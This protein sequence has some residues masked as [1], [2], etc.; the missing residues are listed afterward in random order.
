MAIT[1]KPLIN[2]FW[3]RGA[4]HE[5]GIP[6]DFSHT[7]P[8]NKTQIFVLSP[9]VA[10]AAEKLVRS[11][12]FKFPDLKDHHMPYEHTA[13]EYEITPEIHAI[14]TASDHL[15]PQQSEIATITNIGAH[16]WESGPSRFICT[17]YWRLA[18]G[19]M[20]HS[21]FSFT[22]GMN[23]LDTHKILLSPKKVMEGA[24]E[25]GV[26]LS[27]AVLAGFQKANVPTDSILERL[28]AGFSGSSDKEA[29]AVLNHVRE[30]ISELPLL[31]FACA[32]L[33]NC[34]TGVEKKHVAERK[35][36]NSAYGARLRKKMSSAAF[37]VVHLSALEKVSDDGTIT[38]NVGM[39]AHYVR[40]HFKQ[41][42][43]GVYWW[44]PFVRGSGEPR[45]RAAYAVKE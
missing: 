39:A 32:M 18:N 26:I 14:R 15:Y 5:H 16:V 8:P 20:Q 22:L 7:A 12:S 45:K 17:P 9:E 1:N 11:E 37:T 25:T 43:S 13:I 31:A 33:I 23:E 3:D 44:S 2:L 41:R 6:V 19:Q 28:S 30:S 35:F 40:G 36:R 29:V 24:I 10:L 21:F 38:S 34:K 4:G 27:V 42:K